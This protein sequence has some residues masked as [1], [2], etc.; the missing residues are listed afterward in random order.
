MTPSKQPVKKPNG[1]LANKPKKSSRFGVGVAIGAAVGAAAAALLSPRSGKQNRALLKKKAAELEKFLKDKD[2]DKK[3][4]EIFGTVTA[5]AKKTYQEAKKELMNRVSEIDFSKGLD[6]KTYEKLV[7]EVVG[8]AQKTIKNPQ[9]AVANLQ[10]EFS[11]YFNKLIA[12]SKKETKKTVKKAVK[13]LPK[14]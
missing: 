8:K 2:V 13:K 7:S 5:D 6:R 1:N 4:K 12:T 11:G 9:K 3:V 14:K 10:K